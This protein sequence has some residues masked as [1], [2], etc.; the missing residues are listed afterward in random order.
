MVFGLMKSDKDSSKAAQTNHKAAPKQVQEQASKRSAKIEERLDEV[1]QNC[2][3]LDKRRS[4]DLV[5]LQA[6]YDKM[7]HELRAL[8]NVSKTY[9]SSMQKTQDAK[10]EVCVWSRVLGLCLCLCAFCS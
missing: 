3:P 2:S 10:F 8:V 7:K 9:R 5:P 6:E 1:V 4:P